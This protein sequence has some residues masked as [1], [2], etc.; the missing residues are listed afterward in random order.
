M[1]DCSILLVPD[2]LDFLVPF[3]CENGGEMIGLQISK[4][5]RNHRET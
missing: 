5:C 3:E 2:L 4:V 1:G